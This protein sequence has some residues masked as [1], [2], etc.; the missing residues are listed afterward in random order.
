M[1]EPFHSLSLSSPL[2]KIPNHFHQAIIFLFKHTIC[3]SLFL[4][5][6]FSPFILNFLTLTSLRTWCSEY[7]ASVGFSSV[8]ASGKVL[9]EIE[10]ESESVSLRS[11]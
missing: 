10:E 8:I 9:R 11:C 1:V 4:S 3:F 7:G 6:I 5:P 2:H